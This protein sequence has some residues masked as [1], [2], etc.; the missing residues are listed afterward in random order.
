MNRLFIMRHGGS[1][2]NED[3]AFY[4]L[5]DS[6]ICLTTNGIRQ[7]L[8]SAA[9]LSG[10]TPR[11]KKPGDFEVEA[12][13]SEYAR[14]KQ[15]AR[16][17]LDQM[18][19]LSLKPRIQ[20]LINERDYGTKYVPKMDRDPNYHA[21]HSESAVNARRRVA[22]FIRQIDAVLYRSDVI[23]FSHFGTIRALIAELLELS[24]VDMMQRDVPN[25]AVF[26]FERSFV[27]GKARFS[28]TQ[29]PDRILKKTASL[30][31]MPTKMMSV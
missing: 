9:V 30:I 22:T 10:V 23:A 17:V 13:T 29:L 21:H 28:Q 8:A 5:N 14:A 18:G 4:A 11:W 24:D 16:I 26:L 19:L 25:G 27:A 31:R 6:A 7:C 12:Y 2:G 20:P 15:T 3:P 1:T